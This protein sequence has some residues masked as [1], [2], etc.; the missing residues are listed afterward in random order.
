VTGDEK[1]DPRVAAR[2]ALDQVMPSLQPLLESV[3]GLRQEFVAAGF[4]PEAA[5]GMAA[6]VYKGLVRKIFGL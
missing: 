5:D 4:T 3:V 1:P 6:E 2:A